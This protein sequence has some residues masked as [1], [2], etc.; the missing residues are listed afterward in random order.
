MK[1]FLILITLSCLC[2]SLNAQENW[3]DSEDESVPDTTKFTFGVNLGAYF[4]N[5][6]T[7]VLYT[8]SPSVTPYGVEFI[9]AQ[10]FNQ[11]RFQDYFVHPY[12]VVEYTLDPRYR[13]GFE[14]GGHLGYR[15]LP[16]FNAFFDFN[17]TQLDVEQFF[18]VA[19]QD[20]F[21]GIPGPTFQQV[22]IVGEENRFFLNL[23]MQYDYFKEENAAAYLALFGHV[24]NILMQRN[25]FVLDG[26]EYSIFHFNPNTSNQRPGGNSIGF[27]S[28]TGFKFKF[29]EHIWVDLMYQFYYSEIKL[30][31]VVTESGLQH[32]LGIRII[33]R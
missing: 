8:G 25:Y 28:G 16:R 26:Q 4:P 27:G 33:W 21:N 12:E 32:T 13:S 24:N 11:Q 17:L 22:P 18:T 30:T 14:L 10:P 3:Y 31:E 2:S 23:G 5:H 9:F 29:Y 19:I 20:P 1:V 6:N 7:A 15:F